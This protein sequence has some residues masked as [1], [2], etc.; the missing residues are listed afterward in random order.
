MKTFMKIAGVLAC[1]MAGTILAQEP[2]WSPANVKE[3]ARACLVS[4]MDGYMNAIFKHGRTV[5]PPLAKD[6]RM[7][8]NTGQS[9]GK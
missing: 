9:T 5:V 6:V 4:I 3:C 8:E 2:V 1:A 7:T